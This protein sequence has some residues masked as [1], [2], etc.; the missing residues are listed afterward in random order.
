MELSVE[1]KAALDAYFGNTPKKKQNPFQ[2]FG[3]SG[4]RAAKSTL[5]G[6]VGI[7][8]IVNAPLDYIISQTGSDFRFGSPT[9]AARQGFDSLTAGTPYSTAPRN[10]SERIADTAGEFVASALPYNAVATGAKALAP[11][12]TKT[13]KGLAS[14][15]G[16]G[17]GTEYARQEMPD[18]T[19]APLLGGIV[20][21]VIPSAAD[22][23]ISA[24]SNVMGAAR[25][26]VNSLFGN[27]T[28]QQSAERAA[29]ATARTLQDE[30]IDLVQAAKR[31]QEA[32]KLGIPITLPEAARSSTLLQR[33]EV[34]ER[35]AG[36][37][38]NILRG[39]KADRT[40]QVR[41]ALKGYAEN[42][43]NKSVKK[44]DP[45][46]KALADVELPSET[47]QGLKSNP[48][49]ANAYKAFSKNNELA[50]KVKDYKANSVGYVNELKKYLD[51]K[52][53]TFTENVYQKDV[54]S[55]AAKRITG[56]IDA[57]L[58]KY[59]EARAVARPGIVARDEILKPL[60]ATRDNS[61]AVIRGRIFGS[62]KQRKELARG[63]GKENFQNL[64]KL[65]GYVDDAIAGSRQQSATA[66]KIAAQREL[67]TVTGAKGAELVGKPLNAIG[68]FA[69]WYSQKARQ[70][71]YKAIAELYT[72]ADISR[73]QKVL[74]QTPKPQ[75]ANTIAE[76]LA[77]KT[78]AVTAGM[79]TQSNPQSQETTLSPEEKAAL[80][81]Y[82]K[83][84]QQEEA[85][86]TQQVPSIPK[87]AI[88]RLVN[89][90]TL[91]EKFDE[92]Y[93][94]GESQRILGTV[95]DNQ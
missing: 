14:L 19:L 59:A 87:R 58:P 54:Y 4:A 70:R 6:I 51:A 15:L 12:A 63:L 94:V 50:F 55:D 49:I 45:L 72:S 38:A 76:F 1:E 20:G 66:E 26:G 82:F 30:G 75:R 33:Q 25:R 65:M 93:G 11:L 68:K 52:S 5:A 40:G 84:A 39:Y 85:P 29:R 34:V 79:S 86:T 48:A 37:G 81:A 78:P 36:E 21:A 74:A 62:P 91:A 47:I 89:D 67:E 80:D 46:Y 56:T 24:P 57:A 16:A 28:P 27:F 43:V 2:E 95:Y 8:D 77:Q 90:P 3:R 69:D 60:D 7:G 83:N 22:N 10:N 44:S 35:G 17:A 61:M 88:R 31:M 53:Q 13:G 23:L 42:I 41:D 32:K 71:D 73:L 18:S 64:S 92:M 9:D